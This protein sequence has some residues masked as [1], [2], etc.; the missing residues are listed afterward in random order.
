MRKSFMGTKK[1]TSFGKP[2]WWY[3]P[4]AEKHDSDWSADKQDYRFNQV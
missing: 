1:D 4:Q 3:Y 2:W